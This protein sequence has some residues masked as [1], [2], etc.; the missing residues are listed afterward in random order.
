MARGDAFVDAYISI[1]A[2]STVE[3]RPA[4]GVE[5][6]IFHIVGKIQSNIVKMYGK[7]SSGNETSEYE[8]GM[9]AGETTATY[10]NFLTYF[11]NRS[12]KIIIT[13]QEYITLKTGTS[14]STLSIYGIQLK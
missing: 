3:I 1:P 11:F 5:I 10:V 4:N 12:A 13:N 7:D 9:Q 8:F 2:N 14:A 6:M